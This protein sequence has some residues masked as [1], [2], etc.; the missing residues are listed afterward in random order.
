MIIGTNLDFIAEAWG[1][2]GRDF[3][4]D[5]VREV[6]QVKGFGGGTFEYTLELKTLRRAAGPSPFGLA[7]VSLLACVCPFYR[8]AF[9]SLCSM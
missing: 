6:L 4:V 8:D 1:F 7:L 5:L 2:A 3:A 9:H